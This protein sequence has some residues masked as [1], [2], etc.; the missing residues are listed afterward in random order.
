MAHTVTILADHKGVARPSVVGDEYVVDA[1]V[2]IS[3]YVAGGNT[4]LA[5]EFG[6]STI[7]AATITGIANMA[8]YPFL[9]TSEAGAYLSSS[10]VKMV[11][12][13]VLLATSAENTNLTHSGQQFNV[14]VWGQL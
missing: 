2:D 5:S 7:T 6:L 11:V 8:F 1:V 4:L 3:T 10:S 14:R 12:I 9:Q 13:N